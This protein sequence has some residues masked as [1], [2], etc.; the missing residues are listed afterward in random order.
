MLKNCPVKP[1]PV[2]IIN[3]HDKYLKISPTTKYELRIVNERTHRPRD[4]L[5]TIFCSLPKTGSSF[6]QTIALAFERGRS[7]QSREILSERDS[8]QVLLRFVWHRSRNLFS[9]EQSESS[10]FR[11]HICN[12]N[13]GEQ[14]ESSG[15]FFDM[16][17]SPTQSWGGVLRKIQ[18]FKKKNK[19]LFFTGR[20][21]WDN[22]YAD[23]KSGVNVY[24]VCKTNQLQIGWV[25]KKIYFSSKHFSFLRTNN[26]F[27]SFW[28]CCF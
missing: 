22:F 27:S 25:Y 24:A 5:P 7:S 21:S 4:R 6:W 10:G 18:N 14:S 8:L 23:S 12:T 20:F 13:S 1:D 9:G 17:Y 26:N 11:G 15:L 3:F 16:R 2:A 28:C 19:F